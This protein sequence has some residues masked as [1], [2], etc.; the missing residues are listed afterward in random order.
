MR[1]AGRRTWVIPDCE[2]PSPGKGPMTAHESVIVVNDSGRTAEIVVELFFTDSHIG[3]RILWTVEP[4]RVRCF[5]LGTPAD[6]GGYAVPVDTQ[7]AL[8]LTSNVPIVVQYGRLDDRQE[9]LAYYTTIG[10]SEA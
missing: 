6:M 10:Y 3:G 4:K 7:Y 8:K 2:H 5:R 9:N 1:A